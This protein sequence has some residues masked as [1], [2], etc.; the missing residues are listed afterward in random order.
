MSDE[1][2]TYQLIVRQIPEAGSGLDDLLQILQGEYGLDAYTAKQ[3]LIGPGLVMFGKGGLEKTGKIAALLYRY[4][5]SSWQIV[6]S[7]PDVTPSRLLTLEIRQDDIQFET[8]DG[9]VRLTR[10][11]AVVAVF[12][13]LSGGLIDKHVKR[14]LAQNTYRGRNALEP[15][16]GE[17]MIPTILQGKPV[18]DF[19]LLDNHGQVQSAIRVL[20]GRFNHTG[21]GERAT[22][23]SRGN[24]EAMLT[25]VKEYAQPFRVHCDFGLSQLPKCQVQR[26]E[27]GPSSLESNLKSLN[28]YGWLLTRLQGEG[29]PED[30]SALNGAQVGGVVSAAVIGQPA[31]GA[32]L[33]ADGLATAAPGLGEVSQEIRAALRDEEGPDVAVNKRMKSPAKKD[34]PPP[35]ERPAIRMTMR[36]MLTLVGTFAGV[37][38]LVLVMEGDSH[39]LRV[40][41]KYCTQAGAVPGLIAFGLLWSGL[42]FIRLKRKIENTPTSKVRSIAMGLVEVHGQAW[43]QY[44]LVA[45][46]TQS[47]C[48]YYRLRKYRRQEKNKWRLVKDV[49]SSHV[50]FQID[51]GTGRVV[52]APQ[53]AS[54]KAKTRQTGFPGQSPLTFTA[55][56]SADENEKWVEDII[57]EGTSLYVLGFARPLRAERRSL[58][59]RSVEKLRELKL[60]RRALHRYDTDGDG[61]ISEDEWQVARSDAEQAALK[62][63]LAEGSGRKRQEEHI[64]IAR[65]SQRGM[66]F[67]IAEVASEAQL[68]R[69]YGLISIPLLVVGLVVAGFALFKL[70]EFIGV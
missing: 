47:A 33:G 13:D 53:G 6:P 51:D 16:T 38:L 28:H 34:L 21:L 65:P 35:P 52:V 46:M 63:H 19:Y 23:S 26:L 54:V 45:P 68:I 70:L 14:I 61:Q 1:T 67:V 62:E 59:E 9:P 57:Y 18:L 22:M 69:N 10:G 5:F 32:I 43:R 7:P 44:A 11:T 50:A 12:A 30:T 55:F 2:K 8:K 40:V 31:L 42:H 41:V 29:R 48:V 4:G 27:D 58:R 24:L 36:K 60:D 49:D 66:P 37:A 20:P 15:L 25:L 17:E 64:V 56:D 3:R 39:L